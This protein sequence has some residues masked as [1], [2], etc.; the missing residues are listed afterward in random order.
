MGKWFRISAWGKYLDAY[1]LYEKIGRTLPSMKGLKIKPK[2][3]NIGQKRVWA[4]FEKKQ[5]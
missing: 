4:V 1:E 5:R 3:P 2:G